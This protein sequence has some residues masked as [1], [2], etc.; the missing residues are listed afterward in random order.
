MKTDVSGPENVILDRYVLGLN[1]QP[2][3]SVNL[4]IFAAG[5]RRSTTIRLN[6]TQQVRGRR[7][8]RCSRVVECTIQ[9]K[10]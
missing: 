6:Y 7:F 2:A 1:D 3:E 5:Q 9:A 8:H 4:W 10:G